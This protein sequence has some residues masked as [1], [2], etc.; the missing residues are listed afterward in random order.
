M[1]M[2]KYEK[3]KKPCLLTSTAERTLRVGLLLILAA[4]IPLGLEVSATAPYSPATAED[5]GKML[6]YPVAALALLTA[7]VFLLDRVVRAERKYF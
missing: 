1:N 2:R 6:E 3:T 5:Y 4:L 7:L